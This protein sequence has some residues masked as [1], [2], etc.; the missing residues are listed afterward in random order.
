MQSIDFKIN[1]KENTYFVIRCVISAFFYLMIG[2][3]LISIFSLP[4]FMFI[5]LIP[6]FF[7]GF[8]F[9]VYYF[10]T[11]GIMAGH[12]RGNG[13]RVTDNQFPEIYNICKKQCEQLH[14]DVPPVYLIQSGGILN[15]YAAKFVGK[16]YVVIFSEIFDLAFEGGTDELSF[17]I[18]HELGHI[19]RNHISKFFW[20]FPSK[21]IPFLGSAYSRACEYTCDNI[22]NAISPN[23][24]KSGLLILASGKVGYKK[25]NVQEYINSAKKETGFWK[26][27][28]E[29]VSSHPD[30]PHRIENIG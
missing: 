5:Q 1:P 22:A 25:V 20:L 27:F 15:A 4:D 11:V 13:I 26:W 28:S 16:N 17:V 6:I 2:L 10:F 9:A 3:S 14:I 18:A 8:I 24:S 12:I 21:I 29:K 7:Y 30:F 19:K 23:G